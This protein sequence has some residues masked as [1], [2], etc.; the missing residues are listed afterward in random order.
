MRVI[1]DAFE[2]I[3]EASGISNIEEIVTTFVKAEEQNHSLYNYVN[4]LNTET[5][6]LEESNRDIND[7]INRIIE[8]GQMSDKEK[9]NLQ[10]QLEDEC[11]H[12]ESEINRNIKEADETKTIFKRIQP[13]VEKMIREFAKTKFFLS[14][15]NKQHYEAGFNF[16][17][18]NIISYLAELEEYVAILITYLATKRD[19]PVAPF[20]L[21][22][23]DKLDIK[24]HNKKEIA[25]SYKFNFIFH[26]I[27]RCTSG[28]CPQSGQCTTGRWIFGLGWQCRHRER[29]HQLEAA[30]SDIYEARR[31]RRHQ[32][33]HTRTGQPRKQP[34]GR[35]QQTY[36]GR[37][38]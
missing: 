10:K 11:A 29:D 25:V 14:V 20:A 26:H 37:C 16:N 13:N 8:R 35:I 28:L 1:E 15:A 24:N 6:V 18:G 30:V 32:L 21:I 27:D 9:R 3:K 17:E 22:P 19:D 7:Q 2:Q 34:A 23:L 36:H 31:R 12:L 5:D 33:Y 4:M 38:S